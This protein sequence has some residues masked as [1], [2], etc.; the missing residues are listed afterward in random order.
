MSKKHHPHEHEAAA[1]NE[2]APEVS[3][4]TAAVDESTAKL[5]DQRDQI[6]RLHAEIENMH[7][8][9]ERDVASAHK[10]AS[11]KFARDLLPVLDSLEMAIQKEQGAG[12]DTLLE[13]VELTHKLLLDTLAKHGIKQIDPDGERFDPE[14]HEAVSMQ[15]NADVDPNTVLVVAQKGYTLNGR[16]LR[17]ARV[18]VSV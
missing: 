15:P 17:P 13:G 3:E 1:E 16:L 14:L 4:G 11:E 10:Y 12:V 9:N 7:R 8:R 2:A 18:V 6:L 5:A